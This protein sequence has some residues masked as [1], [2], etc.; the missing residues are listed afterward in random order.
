MA[1]GISVNG[2]RVTYVEKVTRLDV[3]YH[4]EEVAVKV[5]EIEMPEGVETKITIDTKLPL[6]E[7]E[8]II[9]EVWDFLYGGD[10]HDI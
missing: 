3:R 1:L 10:A 6:E 4:E 8:K 5:V 2:Y 7:S 9:A